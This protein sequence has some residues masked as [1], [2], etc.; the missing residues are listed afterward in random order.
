MFYVII[1]TDAGDSMTYH[2]GRPFSTKDRNNEGGGRC[3]KSHKG[4]WWYNSCHLA[5][6]NG[7]Y[8]KGPH[9]TF[10]DGI[11]WQTWQGYQYS[12]KTVE[13]KIRPLH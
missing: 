10:A 7:L 6:L 3:A 1:I 11:E 9:D 13:M 5:N 4:A 8:L 2:A 12:L